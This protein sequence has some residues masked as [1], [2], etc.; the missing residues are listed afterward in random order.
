MLYEA[1]LINST[2]RYIELQVVLDK[3]RERATLEV[4]MR[5]AV[6]QPQRIL[7]KIFAYADRRTLMP[8]FRDETDNPMCH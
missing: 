2:I 6:S 5:R 8:M 4:Q 3:F 1:S 7:Q